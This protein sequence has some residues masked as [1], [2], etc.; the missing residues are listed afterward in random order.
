MKKEKWY[1]WDVNYRLKTTSV[2]T[3]LA[4]TK[5]EA[6]ERAEKFLENATRDELVD[7]FLAALT[8]S[9]NFTITSI[10]NIEEVTDETE[11][12]F[13]NIKEGHNNDAE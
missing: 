11:K 10:E 3:V 1:Y 5:T 8:F 4:R 13:F 6:R 2:F 9:P 12:E 7:L